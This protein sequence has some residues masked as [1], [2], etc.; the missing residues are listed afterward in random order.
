MYSHSELAG[1]TWFKKH[2]SNVT[3]AYCHMKAPIS[4]EWSTGL[5]NLLVKDQSDSLLPDQVQPGTTST[6]LMLKWVCLRLLPDGL[7]QICRTLGIND[8][9]TRTP[10]PLTCTN[11][12]RMSR[13]TVAS[14]NQSCEIGLCEASISYQTGIE[15]C[16]LSHTQD[17]AWTFNMSMEVILRRRSRRRGRKGRL[18]RS[19]RSIP[20][21]EK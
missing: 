17:S 10:F 4:S 12:I 11:C 18:W 13:S 1:L 14:Y 5:C 15:H 21:K 16:Y 6:L 20:G 9:V 7:G 2:I 8:I 3:M 19:Q